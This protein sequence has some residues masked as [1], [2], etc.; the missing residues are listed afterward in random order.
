[1]CWGYN[2]SGQLGD[3]TQVS[4]TTPTSIDS[5]T[6]VLYNSVAAGASHT[7]GITTSNALRCWGDDTA[8]K[9]GLGTIFNVPVPIW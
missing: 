9:T 4:K 7:C 5:A 1:M 6:P 3:A 8:G 2:L